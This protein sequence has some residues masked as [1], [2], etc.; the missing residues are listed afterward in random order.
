M[1]SGWL[2]QQLQDFALGIAVIFWL[3]V[4]L[5][6]VAAFINDWRASAELTTARSRSTSRL[7]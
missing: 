7:G 1:G 2:W 5:K 4:A 3:W 6:A